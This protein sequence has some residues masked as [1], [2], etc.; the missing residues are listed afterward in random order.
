MRALSPEVARLAHRIGGRLG[1]PSENT[2]S[3]RAHGHSG[4]MDAPGCIDCA[5]RPVMCCGRCNTMRC[6]VHALRPDERCDRCEHDWDDE[7]VTRRAA[8]LIFTPPIAILSG[9]LLFG[10]LLPVSLGGAIGAA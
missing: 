4:V 8:K 5:T 3:H 1:L 2:C 9:G 6:E 7:A 10:L